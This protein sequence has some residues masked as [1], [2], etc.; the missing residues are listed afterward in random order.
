MCHPERFE[1]IDNVEWLK[2]TL[3]KIFKNIQI[4]EDFSEGF[5][6]YIFGVGP[7]SQRDGSDRLLLYKKDT[8]SW[9]VFN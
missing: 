2:K 7:V 8:E 9:E 1:S 4:D 3:G 6:A 5:E